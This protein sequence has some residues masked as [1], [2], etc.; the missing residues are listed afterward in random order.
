MS[1]SIQTEVCNHS[2]LSIITLVILFINF[3]LLI[4]NNIILLLTIYDILKAVGFFYFS[5]RLYT[6][7]TRLLQPYTICCR[8]EM[9]EK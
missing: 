8:F 7:Y 3:F 2:Y 6:T 9:Y 4:I 5:I 1:D